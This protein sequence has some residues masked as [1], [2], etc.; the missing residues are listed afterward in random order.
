MLKAHK[1]MFH[2]KTHIGYSNDILDPFWSR[3]ALFKKIN[4]IK[5][6]MSNEP[7]KNNF[8]VEAN[9]SLA[10]KKKPL[11]T[12]PN[13]DHLI[14]RILIERR[15]SNQRTVLIMLSIL[16]VAIFLFVSFLQN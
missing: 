9:E 3:Q 11:K 2:I 1:S 10:H 16:L 5:Q 7:K 8:S 15:K 14:K 13:I 4:N 12:R 6:D